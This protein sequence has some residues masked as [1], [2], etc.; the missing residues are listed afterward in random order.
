MAKL[1]DSKVTGIARVLRSVADEPGAVARFT[2][3]PRTVDVTVRDIDG[4]P[5]FVAT[6]GAVV[7]AGPT[8]HAGGEARY[9]F[10]PD[11]LRPASRHVARQLMA[12]GWQ[13]PEL[14]LVEVIRPA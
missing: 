6:W 2:K 11:Y 14:A 8:V 10:D 12:R 13:D 5:T 4:V 9:P 1:D 3:G 7:T